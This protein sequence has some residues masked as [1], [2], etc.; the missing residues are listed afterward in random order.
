MANLSIKYSTSVRT[1]TNEQKL[2]E[3]LA[4][5]DRKAVE[6]IYMRHFNMVQSLILSNNGYPDDARDIFQ[7]A[8]IILYEKARS[9]SFELNCQLKTYLYSVC[10]RLWLKRLSQLQRI[11]PEVGKLEEAVSVEDDLERHEQRNKE[12]QVM[13]QCLASLGEPCKSLL[14]AYYLDRKSMTEI[15]ADFGYTNADNA[16]NQK[17]KC[18]MRLKKLFS[19]YITNK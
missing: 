1:E 15:A 11:S 6:T 13:E 16:K 8:M 10:R 9:G 12:F 4:L 17:Y 19:Q 5:N 2:L 14:E 7:E 3:G 18:L